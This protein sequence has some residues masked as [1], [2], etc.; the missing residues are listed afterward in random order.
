MKR[1]AIIKLFSGLL[2]LLACLTVVAIILIGQKFFGKGDIYPF[3]FW[4]IPLAIGLSVGGQA[5]LDLFKTKIFVLRLLLILLTTGLISFCWV[6]FVYLIL[7]PW[8]NAFSFPIFYLWVIGNTIQLLF[9]DRYLPKRIAQQKIPGI[10]LRLLA[11][12]LTL[13]LVV[14]V[15]LSLSYFKDYLTRPEKEIYLIPGNFEGK[16]RVIYGENC[17]EQPLYENGRR[18]MKIPDS[19]ILI[20]Q[21]KFQSGWVDNEYYLI[22][23]NGKR[24]KLDQL[25]DHKERLI[26]SPGVL[27]GGSGSM[28]GE[29]PDGSSSSESP[30]AIHFTDFTIYN[31]NTATLSDRQYTLTERKFDSLTTA[32]VGKCRQTK[33]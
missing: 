24:T 5:I 15:I 28:G 17:G 3:F 22:D 18:V 23:D 29:M 27:M 7:G 11:F 21:P 25:F 32:L 1:P 26:G 6:Y 19:G 14:I 33:K 8:I 13:V 12:P 4:T 2:N 20:I 16:F 31:K 9:L 10:F 30:L